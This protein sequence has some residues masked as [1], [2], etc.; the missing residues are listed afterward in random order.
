[1][2]L[3][4]AGALGVAHVVGVLTDAPILR[5]AEVFALALLLAYAL[6][7][8]LPS[9]RW[10]V[11]A[12]LAVLIFDAVRTMPSGRVDYGWQVFRYEP[13]EL[14]GRLRDGLELTWAALV[15]VLVL[16]LVARRHAGR[17]SRWALVG[18]VLTGGLVLGYLAVRVAHGL[19]KA[20]PAWAGDGG[21]SDSI[22]FVTAALTPPLV[23][24]LGA[25]ALATMLVGQGRRLA[26]CGAGLLALAAMFHLDTA[27]ALGPQRLSAYPVDPGVVF[28]Q[29]FTFTPTL[30]TAPALTSA[31][32]LAGC[33]L[34]VVGLCGGRPERTGSAGG[35]PAPVDG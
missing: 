27:M 34:L 8:G 7:A 16:A 9:P 12:G 17:P 22:E 33:L 29:V 11:P 5:Q 31:A 32:E 23:L 13:L 30:A 21:R 18:A 25:I 15:V 10:A 20:R 28:T 35:E 19:R 4:A 3:V 2:L 14:S 26:A 24:A 1:M 6:F